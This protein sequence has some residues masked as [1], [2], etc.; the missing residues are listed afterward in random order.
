LLQIQAG[1]Y[2]IVYSGKKYGK[3]VEWSDNLI[4]NNATQSDTTVI[5]PR[6]LRTARHNNSTKYSFTYYNCN[7]L[8]NGLIVDKYPNGN[9]RVKGNFKNGKALSKIERFD[10]NGHIYPDE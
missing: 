7:E 5:I 3:S 8:A 10:I 2:Q 9:I 1:L 4:I 6:I